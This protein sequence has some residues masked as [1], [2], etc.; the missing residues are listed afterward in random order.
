MN[1]WI[2]KHYK[3]NLYEVLFVAKHTEI[4]EDMVVYKALYWNNEIWIRPKIMFLENIE[5][6]WKFIPR[7][8]YVWN[9]KYKHV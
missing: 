1:L 8:E 6:N 5:I 3:W 7:F 2:F 4:L 9:K